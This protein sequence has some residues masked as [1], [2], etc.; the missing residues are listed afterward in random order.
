[1]RR[2]LVLYDSKT[3][4]TRRMAEHV[5]AGAGS[6]PE[7]E[8]RLLP[9]EEASADDLAWCDGLAVGSPTN[10]GV[11]SWKMKRFWDETA[12]AVWGRMDGKIGCAFSSSGGWGGGAELA[13]MSLLTILMNFGMLVFGVRDYVA[14]Q[15]T[16]H[17]GAVLAGEPR[18]EREIDSCRCLGMRLAEM[19]AGR[20]KNIG[21]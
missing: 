14:K 11:L 13:C 8:V 7:T 12:A 18:A 1:M 19:A 20:S 21:S 15:F 17:Y 4:N 5:A 2:I 3:G 16:L 10:M 9:I 6:V